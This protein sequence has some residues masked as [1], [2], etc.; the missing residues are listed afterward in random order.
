V[1]ELKNVVERSVY[2]CAPDADSVPVLVLDPF[3]SPWR[4]PPRAVPNPSPFAPS[5]DTSS[6]RVSSVPAMEDAPG[7]DPQGGQLS[8]L[9]S[10]AAFERSRLR[11]GLDAAGNNQRIAAEQ[12]GL[13]YHQLRR[14]LTKHGLTARRMPGASV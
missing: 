11:A 4:P 13:G 5:P 12:M 10:V 9:E 1:R 8:F 7:P 2:Q 3:D 14:L 6:P